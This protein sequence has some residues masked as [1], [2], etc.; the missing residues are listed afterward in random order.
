MSK[1]QPQKLTEIQY[2]SIMHKICHIFCH[3]EAQNVTKWNII[4]IYHCKIV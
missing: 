3:I 1:I 4:L 2:L